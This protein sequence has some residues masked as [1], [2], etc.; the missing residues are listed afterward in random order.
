MQT[1]SHRVRSTRVSNNG[2]GNRGKSQRRGTRGSKAPPGR[3]GGVHNSRDSRRGSTSTNRGNKRRSE[4]A[5]RQRKRRPRRTPGNR[6]NQVADYSDISDNSDDDI[7]ISGITTLKSKGSQTNLAGLYSFSTVIELEQ[8]VTTLVDCYEKIIKHSPSIN[9]YTD[10]LENKGQLPI[11]LVPAFSRY[12]LKLAAELKTLYEQKSYPFLEEIVTYRLRYSPDKTDPI[13]EELHEDVDI[14]TESE[15]DEAAAAT[16]NS[17][18]INNKVAEENTNINNDL[19]DEDDLSEP[20]SQLYQGEKNKT[21]T[22][23]TINETTV[24]EFPRYTDEESNSGYEDS[25]S[26]HSDDSRSSNPSI[27]E[28]DSD[29]DFQEDM[30]S[31]HLRGETT[32][33]DNSKT[34]LNLEATK[35]ET[36]NED[37]DD[38]IIILGESQKYAS[39]DNDKKEKE[40]TLEKIVE[41]KPATTI[42]TTSSTTN[43]V[44]NNQNSLN[45]ILCSQDDIYSSLKETWPPKLPDIKDDGIKARV[46]THHS[47]L[48]NQPYLT[49]EE[50]VRNSYERFEFLGDSVVN[51]IITT[52]IYKQFPA[53]DAGQMTRIRTLLV[54]NRRLE[55]WTYLYGLQNYLII[56]K[57]VLKEILNSGEKLYKIYADLFEAYV[58]GLI[59]ENPRENM[60]K[61]RN[62]LA[63]LAKPAIDKII[64]SNSLHDV[65][66]TVNMNAKNE[67]DKILAP[68]GLKAYYVVTSKKSRRQPFTVMECRI[69]GGQ[70]TGIGKA[71]NIRIAQQVAASNILE[72]K[73]LL[74]RL[75]ENV[76]LQKNKGY[77]PKGNINRDSSNLKTE[78]N[79]SSKYQAN[80]VDGGDNYSE[81]YYAPKRTKNQ[82]GDQ[83]FYI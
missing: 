42:A 53:Y 5:S 44:I 25:E 70:I 46:F 23:S 39:Y 31:N 80:S 61:V 58:G 49:P 11:G 32:Q 51:S 67:L 40:K 69:A 19:H 77:D 66:S 17:H 75:L 29:E 41:H 74:D 9:Y 8:A 3:N 60:P 12:Q 26:D 81:Q 64:S 7:Q 82:N 52:I 63:Q 34:P 50:S 65:D 57:R 30:N 76:S 15:D 54:S 1:K 72:K 22:L 38:E 45:D 47:A 79:N 21:P 37:D 62:W 18:G 33:Q 27:I 24:N 14:V 20:I 13:F 83:K 78:S 56:K 43:N 59:E 6:K 10:I 28:L 71:R 16:L 73:D 35:V 48:E 55:K 36:Q 2:S 68:M 4:G